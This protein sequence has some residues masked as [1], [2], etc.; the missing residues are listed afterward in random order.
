MMS[1]SYMRELQ[2]EAAV[3]AAREHQT[4]FVVWPGDDL[5]PPFPFPFLGTYVPERWRPLEGYSALADAT[6]LGADDEPALTPARLARWVEGILDEFPDHTVGFAITEVGPFQ[7]V[8]QA[9]YKLAP[10]WLAT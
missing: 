7:V 5:R 1:L 6:G 3:Q 10:R 8:V 4:P 9:F 2:Q